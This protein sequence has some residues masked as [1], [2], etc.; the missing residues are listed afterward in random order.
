MKLGS[1]YAARTPSTRGSDAQDFVD[2]RSTSP[3][4]LFESQSNDETT[5]TG[6]KEN[7]RAPRVSSES[8]SRRTH[9]LRFDAR[10]AT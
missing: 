7:I 4:L 2:E 10:R 6:R 1:R 3:F 5:S 8:A 9:V